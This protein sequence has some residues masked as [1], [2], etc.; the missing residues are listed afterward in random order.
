[1]SMSTVNLEVLSS[2]S[3]YKKVKIKEAA[4]LLELEKEEK[5]EK[6]R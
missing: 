3:E 1:M 2:I 6:L 4:Y 5:A